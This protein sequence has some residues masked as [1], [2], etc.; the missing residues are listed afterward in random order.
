MHIQCGRVDSKVPV[1]DVIKTLSGFVAE[2]KF[3]FIGMSECSEKSLRRGHAVSRPCSFVGAVV[4]IIDI[5]VHPIAAAEIEVSIMSY[6]EE[7]KKGLFAVKFSC[8]PS[9]NYRS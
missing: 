4:V 1:E 5:Q 9:L 2:G 3:D 7:T 8:P 6:E